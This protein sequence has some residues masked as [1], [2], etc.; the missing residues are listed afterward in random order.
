MAA[1]L[2]AFNLKRL[3][4]DPRN[5]LRPPVGDEM[6]W[7][8]SQFMV[9][10]IGGPNARRDFHINPGDEFF[11]QLEGN[12]VLEY[13]DGS[14]KR[15]GEAIREG[16]VLLLPARIPH[17]AQRP[18]NSVGLV[19]ERLREASE[20]ES[21]AWHCERCDRKLYELTRGEADLLNDLRRVA[22]EFNA[23]EALRTCKACG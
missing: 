8:A 16:D 12:I 5:L 15:R 19:V 7:K 22:T 10:I 1:P 18:A 2:S 11:Y 20:A 3:I 9:M 13:I 17:S 21:Y 4:D 14:G 23:S 6:I